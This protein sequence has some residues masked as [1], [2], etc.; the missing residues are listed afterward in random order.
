MEKMYRLEESE[1]VLGQLRFEEQLG[2]RW[3]K[4]RM[5]CAVDESGGGLEEGGRS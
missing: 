2:F 4:R 1:K 3:M 5:M